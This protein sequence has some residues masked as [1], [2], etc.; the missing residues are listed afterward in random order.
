MK[1]KRGEL[2]VIGRELVVEESD[3]QLSLESSKMEN[4]RPV[5][6]QRDLITGGEGGG[7]TRGGKKARKQVKCL[8]ME[9]LS[10]EEGREGDD[11]GHPTIIRVQKTTVPRASF[12]QLSWDLLLDF[13]PHL[14]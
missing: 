7:A 5:L 11:T 14:H 10:R 2:L 4:T 6:N 8:K 12:H 1:R 9:R 3:R 13:L